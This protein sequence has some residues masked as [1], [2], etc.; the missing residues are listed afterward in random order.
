[1][2]GFGS[3]QKCS[4]VY[5]AGGSEFCVGR[6][7]KVG[8]AIKAAWNKWRKKIDVAE[9]QR[10]CARE[11]ENSWSVTASPCL[12]VSVSCYMAAELSAIHTDSL[13]VQSLARSLAVS[14]F[15]LSLSFSIVSSCGPLSLFFLQSYPSQPYY[16]SGCRSS[17]AQNYTGCPELLRVIGGELHFFNSPRI[18][19]FFMTKVS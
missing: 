11:G 1:M 9:L 12:R 10:L 13:T 14:P 16:T 2:V 6:L 3:R 18:M 8:N 15:S 7:G 17:M 5:Y 19:G 4:T